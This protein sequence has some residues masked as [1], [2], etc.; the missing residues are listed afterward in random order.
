[1]RRQTETNRIESLKSNII[2]NLYYT[3][4]FGGLTFGL[5]RA[6]LV[7]RNGHLAAVD[8]ELSLKR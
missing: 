5:A 3:N 8:T 6:R 4:L 1:M 2:P 7:G